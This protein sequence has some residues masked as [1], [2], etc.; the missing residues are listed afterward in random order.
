MV[1]SLL[2]FPFFSLWRQIHRYHIIIFM[3]H[4]TVDSR[5][6][7]GWQPLRKH[8]TIENLD[9]GLDTLSRYYRFV[10][11]DQAVAMLTGETPILP[12]SM[13]FTFD[14][15]YRNNIT[16]ALPLLRRYKVPATFFL[17]T[18]H[19]ERREPFWYDRLD[20]ALQHLRKEQT[21]CFGNKELLFQ[22]EQIGSLRTTFSALRVA[23]KADTRQYEKIMLDL[24]DIS[25][26]LEDNAGRCLADVFEQDHYTSLMSWDE[27]KRATAEGITLGSH[28]LDHVLLDRLDAISSREQLS[29]SKQMIE[30]HTGT[31]CHHF[32][33]PYGIWNESILKLVQDCGFLSALT[34]RY[35]H[36][37]RGSSLFSLHRINFYQSNDLLLSLLNPYNWCDQ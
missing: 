35:G 23:V 26:V 33:Y 6:P 12:Y 11:L 29:L 22:P 7:N 37:K 20:Y 27:A 13:A 17:S 31:P 28:T 18:N 2:K 16:H 21:V 25:R 5:R 32:C 34:T 36:N 8:L 9:R 15:G 24:A 19:I 30:F 3:V 14:D 1:S 10:S 4:G